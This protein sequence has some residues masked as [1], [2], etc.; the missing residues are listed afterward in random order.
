MNR[1]GKIFLLN[2]GIAVAG[3]LIAVMAFLLANRVSPAF[4]EHIEVNGRIIPLSG[5]GCDYMLDSPLYKSEPVDA[6]LVMNN[7]TEYNI[8]YS[9]DYDV[10]TIDNK[11]GTYSLHR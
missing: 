5:T 6:V 8:S 10:F 1:S 2:A 11:F 9:S 3:I 4:M 7:G